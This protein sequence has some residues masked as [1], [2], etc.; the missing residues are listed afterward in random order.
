LLYYEQALIDKVVYVF[1]QSPKYTVYCVNFE[2]VPIQINTQFPKGTYADVK[3]WVVNEKV[4]SS[5]VFDDFWGKKKHV[6]KAI[7]LGKKKIQ[8]EKRRGTNS[9]N[10]TQ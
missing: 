8:S 9:Y 1:H 5:D 6:S 3:Y 10:I 7:S 2:A 4:S